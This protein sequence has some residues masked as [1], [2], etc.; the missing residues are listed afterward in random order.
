MPI[1]NTTAMILYYAVWR[2]PLLQI[3]QPITLQRSGETFDQIE[4]NK[5]D[6]LYNSEE[7]EP[8]KQTQHAAYIP[9]IV[10]YS[11]GPD[12]LYHAHRA[13]EHNPNSN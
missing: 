5:V 8:Q 2:F 12:L 3:S 11:V 13:G 6:V 1:L 10:V 9:Q 7:T 4:D